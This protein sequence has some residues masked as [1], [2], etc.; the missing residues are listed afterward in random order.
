LTMASMFNCVGCAAS[1]LVV[2]LIVMDTSGDY[3]WIG[4][5]RKGLGK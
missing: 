5:Y 4:V 1:L 3:R 2:L